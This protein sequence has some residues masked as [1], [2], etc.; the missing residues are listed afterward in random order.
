MVVSWN[1]LASERLFC[2]CVVESVKIF[3]PESRIHEFPTLAIFASE[4]T[5]RFGH[6]GNFRRGGIEEQLL[7][8]HSERDCAQ[9]EGIGD[10]SA[11]GEIAISWF[12]SF[13]SL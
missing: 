7:A 10:R 13:A 2:W 3:S 11:E 4:I 12:P 9:V 1:R 5:I 6:I 8:A